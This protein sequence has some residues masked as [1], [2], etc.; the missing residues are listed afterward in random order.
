MPKDREP[1]ALR[2]SLNLSAPTD[3]HQTSS[4]DFV[5][6]TCLQMNPPKLPIQG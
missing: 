6:V 2:A 3:P 1:P 5:C 4:S